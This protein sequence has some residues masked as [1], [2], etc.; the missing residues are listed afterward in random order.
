MLGSNRLFEKFSLRNSIRPLKWSLVAFV[1]ITNLFVVYKQIV[2]Q[3]QTGFPAE[4]SKDTKVYW[5]SYEDVFRWLRQNGPA[6]D[7]IASGLDSMVFLYT[8][9]QAFRPYIANT[10]SL[11][12]TGK[13]APLGTVEEF[14]DIL[15]AYKP[16]YFIHTPMPGFAEEK[17]LDALLQE[18]LSKDPSSLRP[19]YIGKDPRFII[20]EVNLNQGT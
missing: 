17:Y 3:N 12:Y 2:L 15:R 1:I 6:N 4:L 16:K 14:H 9:R 11:F 5:A 19:V 8:G 18:F 7:V 13:S 20:Y 10:T